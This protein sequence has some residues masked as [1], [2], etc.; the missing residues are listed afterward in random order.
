MPLPHRHHSG[1][2]CPL[3]VPKG[4]SKS[5]NRPA[6]LHIPK[7]ASKKPRQT[8][9]QHHCTSL[10]SH[11]HN[12]CFA[13]RRAK[14]R[15]KRRETNPG[16]FKHPQGSY[17]KRQQSRLRP[18]HIIRASSTMGAAQSVEQKAEK[19]VEMQT[20]ATL[21]IPKGWSLENR[22][23]TETVARPQGCF[24]TPRQTGSSTVAHS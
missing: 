21:D 4:A 24:Q 9:F 6:P 23:Q 22:Q 5:A 14:R 2:P 17:E 8:Q 13:K 16:T 10:K 1:P 19:N 3:N 20:P 7:C 11:L 15:G 18:P 12:G